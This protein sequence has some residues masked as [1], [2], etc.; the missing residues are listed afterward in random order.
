V[1]DRQSK[2]PGF[3]Q[4]TL[5][6][7]TVLCVGA[8]GLGSHIGEALARK[9]AG[10]IVLVDDDI[11]EPSNLNRQKFYARDRWKN[12]ALRLSRNIARE[13]FLGSRVTGMAFNFRNALRSGLLPRADC[14]VAGVD[15]D[16]AREQ[17][18]EFCLIN[19]IPCVI[20]AVSEDGDGCYVFIQRVGEA[21]WG[22]AFPRKRR[23]RD[24]PGSYRHPCPGTPAIKD[25]LMVVSGMAVY[26]IDTLFMERPIGWNYRE[27]HLAGY[28]PELVRTVKKQPDCQLCGNR[29]QDDSIHNL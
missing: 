14:V 17:V 16:A 7:S 21:C 20:V 29:E 15:D 8:G 22:C 9:G 27:L 11:V 5:S 24:D 10:D 13:S 1:E 6:S 23:I 28:M 3:N 26:A 25:I 4:Q 19:G 12:K 2:I 18:A